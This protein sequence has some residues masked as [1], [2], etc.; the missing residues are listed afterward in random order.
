MISKVVM[1]EHYFHLSKQ[2]TSF[3][4][5]FVFH[6]LEEVDTLDEVDTEDDDDTELEVDTL[7]MKK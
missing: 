4:L 1:V 5:S 7:K 6:Y 2:K 3:R